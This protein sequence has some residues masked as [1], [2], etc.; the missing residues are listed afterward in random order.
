[1]K[2]WFVANIDDRRGYAFHADTRGKAKS[3]AKRWC[4]FFELDTFDFFTNTYAVRL[5]E[6]DNKPITCEALE[7]AGIDMTF[8][9]EPIGDDFEDLCRCAICSQAR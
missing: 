6:L 8:E 7:Q 4:D 2:A 9:G 5:P 3:Q 1:M